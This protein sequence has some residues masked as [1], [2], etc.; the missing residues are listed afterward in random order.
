MTPV[1]ER[2]PLRVLLVEDSSRIAERIR[3]LVETE[4]GA[5]VVYVAVNE[6]SAI[7]AARE[8]QADVMILDLQ[9]Q[10]GSG[11]GVLQA[12]GSDRPTTIIMTNFALPLYRAKAM[13][14][15][16][17]Y[18]LDKSV[19]FERLLEILEVIHSQRCA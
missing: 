10:R 9:L 16:V 19:D 12:L 11:F 6:E 14:F 13:M 2:K 3:D 8:C 18:F 15:G 7:R 1:P 17:E 5:E 4:V